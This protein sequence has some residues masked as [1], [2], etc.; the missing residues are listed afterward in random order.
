MKAIDYYVN[1]CDDGN[2]MVN[3]KCSYPITKQAYAHNFLNQQLPS[4][5]IATTLLIEIEAEDK[6]HIKYETSDPIWTIIL[7][8]NNCHLE[9]GLPL[10]SHKEHLVAEF[11]IDENL[12][13][14]LNTNEL[15]VSCSL[16][17]DQYVA[18]PLN[19]DIVILY[20]E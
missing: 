9:F 2:C 10:T 6:F 17:A 12:Q 13:P 7:D 20:K 4:N 19:M 8:L 11:P 16:W 5:A 1:F 3:H 14:L 18:C 15:F